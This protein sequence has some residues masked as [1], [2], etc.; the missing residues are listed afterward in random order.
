[1]TQALRPLLTSVADI[2]EPAL[3]CGPIHAD[4]FPDNVLFE[5][6]HITGVIDFYFACIGPFAY[7]LAI[8]LNAWA[9]DAEGMRDGPAFDAF[10]NGY[11]S[12]RPLSQVEDN[13]LPGLGAAAALRFTLTRLHDRLHH[14]P[15]WLVTPK[16]PTPFFRRIDQW[17][18]MGG[19][20]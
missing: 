12:V 7:D 6:G 13:A 10:L 15:N 2:A 11:R 8:A 20:I 4:Y 18:A 9:F 5:D 3:P 16:D 1:M 17:Q 14:D 19:S